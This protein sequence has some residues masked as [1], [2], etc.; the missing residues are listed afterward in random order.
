MTKQRTHWTQFVRGKPRQRG[1]MNKTEQRY[2][3]SL[4]A[5]RIAGEI[6]WYAYEG[7][8][9]KLGKE[10]RYTPDFV[11][12]T[13]DGYL[14]CH[15]TKGFWAEAAKV[16]IKVAAEKFPFRFVAMRAR[17]KKDGGG[18]EATEF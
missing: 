10:C 3:E 4:E 17:A 13:S 18:W 14:E 9:L 5:R 15:E 6:E 1:V 12:M 2:A 7:I 8:T 11:V 16:R